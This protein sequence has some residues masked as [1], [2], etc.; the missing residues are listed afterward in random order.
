MIN[1]ALWFIAGTAIGAVTSYFIT[2]KIVK[3][4]IETEKDKEFEAERKRLKAEYKEKYDKAG[5]AAS[6]IVKE[7][8]ERKE[9]ILNGVSNKRSKHHEES[10][11]VDK[12]SHADFVENLK[13]INDAGYTRYGANRPP[14]H[15]ITD[16]QFNDPK[17]E[18]YYKGLIF[19]YF[20]QDGTVLNEMDERLDEHEIEDS[21]GT[22]FMVYFRDNPDE[23][24]CYVRNDN[25]RIDYTIQCVDEIY[26]GDMQFNDDTEGEE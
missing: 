16:E 25:R 4:Q 26:E 10:V 19:T 23:E 5:K 21:V 9:E 7:N 1:K 6:K 20:K 22:D 3:K 12:P 8:E 2:K 15:V 17:F 18:D 11:P 13:I 24:E 14:H